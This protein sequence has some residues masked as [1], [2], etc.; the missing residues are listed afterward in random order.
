YFGTTFVQNRQFM[1]L[2]YPR[3]GLFLLFCCIAPLL[4]AQDSLRQR[5]RFDVSILNY[6]Q[7]VL[8]YP[9]Q[10]HD[11]GRT[12]VHPLLEAY[13]ADT[14][15]QFDPTLVQDNPIF[16]N[17]LFVNFHTRIDIAKGVGL[18]AGLITEQQ[19]FSNGNFNL[20]RTAIFPQA[21]IEASRHF[22]LLRQ[23]FQVYGAL[24]SFRNFRFMEGL[25]LYGLDLQGIDFNL[26]WKRLRLRYVQIGDISETI[27]LEVDEF[28]SPNL[29]LDS[30]PIGKVWKLD[31][32]VG[33]FWNTHSFQ[34]ATASVGLYRPGGWRLYAQVGHNGHEFERAEAFLGPTTLSQRLAF[35]TG[36]QGK[37]E[38]GRFSVDGRLEYRRYGKRFNLGRK[39]VGV[40]FRDGTTYLFGALGPVRNG[41]YPMQ[42]YARPFAQW[43]FF[44]DFQEGGASSPDRPTVVNV[45]ALTLLADLRFRLHPEIF[46]H[47]ELDHN[48]V[49][50]EGY[51][52]F[53]YP[54]TTFAVEW[55]PAKGNRLGIWLTNKGMDY[56]LHYPTHQLFVQPHF[57]VRAVREL[58][59]W[60]P[61]SWR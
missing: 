54:F 21:R 25:M 17:S 41:H 16:H 36:A 30:V 57:G 18:Y 40:G 6:Y 53:Y 51:A 22:R 8:G 48:L 4:Q 7:T 61:R 9:I 11:P 26:K 14:Y 50:A 2:L 31:A 24:G 3:A 45:S 29:G 38:K 19:G 47:L 12:H 13:R 5:F 58:P 56:Q 10:E 35:V 39:D 52:P 59:S 42:Y 15:F 32:M 55:E 27:G 34:G 1:H 28:Y 23:R 44:T 37:Y 49:F 20:N 60:E 33:L 43:A 46:L